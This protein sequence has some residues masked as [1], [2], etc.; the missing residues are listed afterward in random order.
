MKKILISIPYIFLV[1][2]NVL[3][4][5]GYSEKIFGALGI[6]QFSYTNPTTEFFGFL[7]FPIG[8][9]LVVTYVYARIAARNQVNVITLTSW[10]LLIFGIVLTL[11]YLPDPRLESLFPE[12]FYPGRRW[13]AITLAVL[14]VVGVVVSRMRK[15]RPANNLK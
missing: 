7:C 10:I 11:M 8:P 4:I 9:T 13:I 12:Q 5:I 15:A 6:L 1:A 3:F 14:G 2:L